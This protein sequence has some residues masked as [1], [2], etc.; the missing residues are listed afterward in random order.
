MSLLEKEG[1]TEL[2]STV[3]DLRYRL[4]SAKK[5][6]VELVAKH[7]EELCSYENQFAKLRSQVE[8]GEA[9]RQ[10]LEYEL[11]V[12][13]KQY[14][15]AKIAGE[16]EKANSDRLQAQ[17]KVQIDE[18]QQKMF[19]VENV[20]QAAQ[21]GWQERQ[22]MFESDLR[23]RDNIIQNYM[24][25]QESLVLEKNNLTYLLQKEKLNV[26]EMQQTLLQMETEHSR[27]LE[28]LKEQKNE[29]SYSR[30]KEERLQGELKEAKQ[31]IKDLEENVEAERATHLESKFNSEVIQLR[32]YDLERALEVEKATLA[33]TLSELDMMRKQFCEVE[34]AYYSEKNSAEQLTEKLKKSEQDF[35][36]L[37]N[38]LKS[39]IEQKN[40][41]IAELTGKQKSIEGSC[42]T[43]EE[44][45][46]IT[47]KQLYSLEEAH[48]D[49]LGQLQSVVDNFIP[50]HHEACNETVKPAG[51]S[52]LLET[53][54]HILTDNKNR[55]K[56]LSNKL[57]AGSYAYTRIT[58]EM[59][60]AKAMIQTL[61]H[62]LEKTQAD[63][64]A[65]E[66]ES[67]ILHTRCTDQ[68]CQIAVLQMDLEKAQN[69]WEKAKLRVLECDHERQN[70]AKAY[71]KDI[72]EKLTFLHN[73]YQ[74]LVAG[75]V[76][77]K[78]SQSLLEKFSWVELCTVLE[79]NVDFLISDL[80][81][82]NEKV[83]SL[84]GLCK[85]KSE[86]IKDLQKSHEES[87]KK[88]TEE[89]KTQEMS[90]LKQRRDMEERFVKLIQETQAKARKFQSIAVK[91]KD[92]IAVFEKTKDQV[93]L[94]NVHIKNLL[95]TNEKDHKSLLAACALLAGAL[96]PLYSRT[97]LLASQRHL[98]Q[99][100]TTI[101]VEVRNEIWT[102]IQILSE[103]KEKIQ[104]N[105]KT[106]CQGILLFRRAVI[107]VLTVNRLH[108]LGRSCSSLFTWTD[109]AWK[110]TG[111]MVCTGGTQ[112]MD[113]PTS[114]QDE[115]MRCQE[116]VNW[117]TSSD[118]L[119]A[120][121]ASVS[122]LL[123]VLNKIDPSVPSQVSLIQNA[124]RNSFSKLMKKIAIQMESTAV[125][126]DSGASSGDADSLFHRLALGLQRI[127]SKARGI[128]ETNSSP[129]MKSTEILKSQI[130]EFIQRLHKAEVERRSMRLEL[131]QLKQKI[132][133][134][135]TNT[136][137]AERLNSQ[138]RKSKQTK[139][140]S[141][142]KFK[143]M[144]DELKNALLREQQAQLL[145][146]EQSQQLQELSYRI[147]L[148][149]AEE[150]EKDQ[151][152][153]EAVKSL[154]EAKLELERKGQCLHQLNRQLERM[155]QDK[156]RLQEGI[157]DAEN[158]LWMIAKDREILVKHMKSVDS[159]FEKVRDQM[160]LG[161]SSRND[162]IL[163][164]PKLH[165]EMLPLLEHSGRPEFFACQK[166]IKSFMQ[167]YDF[168]CTKLTTLEREIECHQNHIAELK[169]ELKTACLREN[170]NFP[171]TRYNDNIKEVTKAEY[172][173][174]KT[175]GQDFLP[176]QAEPEMSHSQ[177]KN[178]LE[179]SSFH[180]L[181]TEASS[182]VYY[183]SLPQRR[184]PT[185]S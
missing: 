27:N 141:Y 147:E 169:S 42:I 19:S 29:L 150:A 37:V 84:E 15:V 50:S 168:A 134:L 77:I 32:M 124:A 108:R 41:L 99:H 115:Q 9:V 127:H 74:R 61:C 164:L 75:C 166:M 158:A 64:E 73:L 20:F 176:L 153:T 44:D 131:A 82:A 81:Q 120:V 143:K 104:S 78:K 87:L 70:L 149:S 60:S 30:E 132:F 119:T 68:E 180:L 135:E 129:V 118:L 130:N 91:S 103:T 10:N 114:K 40:N 34:A 133:M 140:V 113:R 159:V 175:N 89:M 107:V 185:T 80:N 88:L 35:C 128:Q 17:F 85:T 92:K 178:G 126:S 3:A 117:F 109:N 171:L 184:L 55:F 33:Q 177:V 26:Q 136:D 151:T 116:A 172:L 13:K 62:N 39:D 1:H 47:K 53:L 90:W 66:R 43:M 5:E 93:A 94:E 165:L 100:Q 6:I 67:H 105:T 146:H 59:K 72:E 49:N 71:Q 155:E 12:A 56:D 148:H 4:N 86:V 76:L 63:L 58:E 98:L 97:C 24:K 38:Q 65:A 144:C 154:S 145:L 57:E 106:Q 125:P 157:R 54:K 22:K 170:E 45:L 95:I 79:E 139:A 8:K 167:V 69:G 181:P 18:L 46:A 2:S 137:S 138:N 179:S 83:A 51:F 142:E 112:V 162:I 25:E 111:I 7:N 152:L 101:S 173:S 110:G 11:A 160:S 16:E 14:R 23:N 174:D 102:L 182:V 156:L 31:R 121:V 163:Q 36:M 123:E 28:T 183:S 48:K 161:C 96:Y 52:V 122:E 21:L